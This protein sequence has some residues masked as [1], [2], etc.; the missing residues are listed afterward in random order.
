VRQFFSY[1]VFMIILK[2]C[3]S[4]HAIDRTPMAPMNLNTEQSLALQAD[5]LVKGLTENRPV[6]LAGILAS[7]VRFGNKDLPRD[8]AIGHLIK[9]FK[10]GKLS[11]SLH[12]ANTPKKAVGL[13]KEFYVN[14]EEENHAIGCIK[15]RQANK[16]DKANKHN[17]QVVSLKLVFGKPKGVWK[18]VTIDWSE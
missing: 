7:E 12:H 15:L 17:E 9:Q 11:N 2:M 6:Y 13:H 4:G 5:I 1:L 8:S 3:V 14:I 18:I 10:N 16:V